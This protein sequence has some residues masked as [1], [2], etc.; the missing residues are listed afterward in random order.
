MDVIANPWFGFV[1]LVERGMT[2]YV[3]IP[4]FLSLLI[5]EWVAFKTIFKSSAWSAGDAMP[6]A[7]S[8]II[9]VGFNMV[10]WA[11]FAATYQWSYN[12]FRLVDL[13]TSTVGSWLIAYV[14]FE[15]FHYA[16]H[17]LA[18]RTGLFWAFHSVHHSSAEMNVLVAS[19][20]MWG[21]LLTNVVTMIF[22]PILGISLIYF[23]T[24]NVITQVYGL[25]TH[26]RLIPKL[27]I[28]EH[29]LVTPANH[30]VHHGRQ[31]KYLDRNYGQSLLIF[32]KLFG[33]HQLHE[34][35][36]EYGLVHHADER[37]PLKF[38]TAGVRSLLRNIASASSLSDKAGYLWRPP[39]WSHTGHHLTTDALR[40]GGGA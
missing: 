12:S 34:E 16:E 10:A 38:Q 24:I 5:T 37:N 13:P 28:L 4:A 32:D 3:I 11:G 40:Q 23:A 30:R 9:G 2:S 31:L 15:F 27:G 19:R 22:M 17:R 8:A 25:F 33:T 6:N 14:V 1:R 35:D 29:V 7:L 18:H 39:G 21:T 36:P 20:I 26:T